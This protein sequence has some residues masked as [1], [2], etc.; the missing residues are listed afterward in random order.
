[1]MDLNQQ[2]QQ[3]SFAY[4]RA[5]TAAAGCAVSEPSV[6]DDSVDLQIAGRRG[7]R[8]R[9]EAQLKCTADT[10]LTSD[11]FSYALPIKNYDDL[12]APEFMVPRILVVVRVPENVD[13]WTEVTDE[14]LLMRRCGY[15]KSLRDMPDR[16]NQA[17]VSVRLC[18]DNRFTVETLAAMMERINQGGVP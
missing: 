4:V 13:E 12:R 9:L 10:V 6:D 11:A 5:V 1:M 15:W 2:K 8:P 14:R 7:M 18:R 3:F 16:D 17:T